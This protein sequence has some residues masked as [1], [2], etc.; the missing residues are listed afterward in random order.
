MEVEA[1]NDIGAAPGDVVQIGL[2]TGK[3]MGVSFFLYIFPIVWLILGAALGQHFSSTLHMSES[4]GS[5]LGGFGFFGL[6]FLI[7]RW[8]SSAL[9]KKNEYQPAISRIVHR[10]AASG[11]SSQD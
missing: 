2:E 11:R 3:L 8:G 6:A 9:M 5:A 10:A 4:A 1:L 7:V